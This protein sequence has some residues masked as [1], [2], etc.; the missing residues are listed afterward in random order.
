M[1]SQHFGANAA[2]WQI[3]LFTANLHILMQRLVLGRAG[4]GERLKKARLNWLSV[5]GR[6]VRHA[7]RQDL[8]LSGGTKALAQLTA[9]RRTIGALHTGATGPWLSRL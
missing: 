8:Q 4:L 3:S 1:P 5:A 6:L 2:W 9:M 7:R